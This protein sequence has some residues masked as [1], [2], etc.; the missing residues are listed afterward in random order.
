MIRSHWV[1]PAGGFSCGHFV[2]NVRTTSA[3]SFCLTGADLVP[4]RGD[5]TQNLRSRADTKAP[6]PAD[7]SYADSPLRLRADRQSILA[8]LVSPSARWVKWPPTAVSLP[9]SSVD[10]RRSKPSQPTGAL[11]PSHRSR[12]LTLSGRRLLGFRQLRC[13]IGRPRNAIRPTCST[14]GHSWL[15]FAGTAPAVRASLGLRLSDD[16]V[17]NTSARPHQLRVSYAER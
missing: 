9:T 4:A 12:R 1:C 6:P 15:I 5:R 10:A 13:A 14:R 7:S 3:R 8:V 17:L 11:L 2:Q 16:A